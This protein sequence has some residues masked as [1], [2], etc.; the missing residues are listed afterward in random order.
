MHLRVLWTQVDDQQKTFSN[1]LIYSQPFNTHFGKSQG[2]SYNIVA[3]NHF[4][5]YCLDLEMWYVW[6]EPNKIGLIVRR[7]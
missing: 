2:Y 6:L 5:Y 4:A 7:K 3:K 1:L